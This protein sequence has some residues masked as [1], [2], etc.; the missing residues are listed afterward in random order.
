MRRT[1]LFFCG[2]LAVVP[3]V[4]GQM[5]M[6]SETRRYFTRV[7]EMVE[8]ITPDKEWVIQQLPD[9]PVYAVNGEYCLSVVALA[10]QGFSV[11]DL[12]GIA[13]PGSQTGR[14]VTMK[15]PLKNVS[16]SLQIPRISYL[17]IAGKLQ[18]HLHKLTSDVRADSVWAGMSLP[19]GYTGKGVLIGISDWGFDYGHPMFMDTTLTNSRI[20]AA[21]DQFKLSGTP[22]AGMNYGAEYNTP[23]ALS[24]A[25]SDTAGTYYGY[26]THGSHVAGI[27]GGSGAGTKYRGVAFE[28][29]YLFASQQLDVGAAIDA[30]HWMKSI[31]DADGKRLVVNMSWGLYHLGT[32]DGTSLLSQVIDNLSSQ[33]VVFV[34][35][36]GNNGD[37]NFHIKKDYNNDSIR[38]RILFYGYTQ[39]TSMWGQC[40]TMWGEPSNPFGVRLEIYN[41]SG[42]LLGTSAVFN[43]QVD[44]GYTDTIMTLGND[45]IFYNFTIDEAHPLN[46]RPH[47]QLRV[48]NTN[49]AYRVVLCSFAPSGRVHYWNV[50]ELSNGVGNWGQPL[51]AFGNNGVTGDPYYSLGEPACTETVITV[52]A[53]ISETVLVSGTVLPGSKASFAS[54]GPTY[55]ERMKPDVSAPGVNIVSSINSYTTAQFTSTAQVIHNGRTYHFA[56]FSGTSMSSPATAGAAAI[57]LQANPNLSPLQVRGILKGTARQ[58]NKT[59]VITWPGNPAWGMGK[60][61]LT[62]AVAMALS[63]VAL[64]SPVSGIDMK[65]FP[66]PTV[67]EL[68]VK[69]PGEFHTTLQ[70]QIISPLGRV[71][72]SGTLDPTEPLQVSSL[73]PG[74]YFLRIT[75]PGRPALVTKFTKGG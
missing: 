9:L 61:T 41:S 19:Q 4:L 53:H 20:R 8:G 27:A 15:I 16:P 43:T 38:T 30:F 24:N 21:W 25:L 28:A 74:I 50:V 26:A 70:Y 31:A 62:D 18:P 1:V 57:L 39:H 23:Q 68:W 51:Q 13:L 75:I 3:S 5:R 32:N 52:A 10:D 58:D 42:A 2:F 6:S 46:A 17:E 56:A 29:E 11:R 34:T 36:A 44:Q 40:I 67:S 66:V 33:G 35:S 12:E 64:E 47:I 55:D 7:V 60:A 45:T 14:V 73:V 48:K 49:T 72:A 65:V 37:V 22:P 71:A 59:G 69:L 54:I 63:T